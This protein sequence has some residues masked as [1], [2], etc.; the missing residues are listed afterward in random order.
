MSMSSNERHERRTSQRFGL[1]PLI[2]VFFAHADAD[3]PTAGLVADVSDG[4][5][6]IVAP[7]TAKPGLHWSDSFTIVISYS[8]Q[9]R[10]ARIEGLTLTAHVVRIAVDATGYHLHA[11]FDRRTADAWDRLQTWINSLSTP[12]VSAEH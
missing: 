5:I 11:R 10:A 12:M 2:P 8:D 7:P 1:K 9:A 4:G 3:T 6:R